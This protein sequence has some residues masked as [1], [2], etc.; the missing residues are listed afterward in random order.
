MRILE[1]FNQAKYIS[2]PTKEFFD[3]LYKKVFLPK[4]KNGNHFDSTQ[5]FNDHILGRQKIPI[6]VGHSFKAQQEQGI[7]EE[8]AEEAT[9][10][11]QA[12]QEVNEETVEAPVEAEPTPLVVKARNSLD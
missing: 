12:I 6:T 2:E 7:A 11:A 10:K 4:V 3:V 9:E 1:T 5:I 8:V